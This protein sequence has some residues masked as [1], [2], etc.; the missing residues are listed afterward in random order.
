MPQSLSS[1]QLNQRSDRSC[2]FSQNVFRCTYS[3]W[4]FYT[5]I[6]IVTGLTSVL[7]PNASVFA[8]S[9][10]HSKP[11][12]TISE[13]AA[14]NNL[15]AK[16]APAVTQRFKELGVPGAIIGVW[17]KGYQPWIKTLGVSNLA[18]STP[19][20]RTDKMRIGSITKTFTGTV[21]L[22]L[23]DE[24]KVSL[25]DPVAKYILNVPN[26]EKITIR[27][28]GN[29][30]SGL[31]NYSEDTALSKKMSVETNIF[32]TPEQLLKIAFRNKPDFLP[33]EKANYS[34][35]NTVLLGMIIEKLTGNTLQNEIR[36]RITDPLGMQQTTFA[37]DG[38]MPRPHS[39]GYLYGTFSDPIVPKGTPPNNVTNNNPS[40]GWAAGAMIST[41]DDLYRYA[42]PLATGKFLSQKT[43]ADRLTWV[44]L[45][46]VQYGFQLG[47]FGGAIGHTGAIGGF[48]S[49]IGYLPEQDAT[50]IILTN[51]QYTWNPTKEGLEPANSLAQIII[52]ELQTQ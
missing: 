19:I 27:Q 35:T 24:G 26:G 2:V 37:I 23:V 7:W 39:Q 25:D 13:S 18:K 22:Q 1:D 44:K 10:I 41:L 50:V 6:G 45:G 30:T 46:E 28:I 17:A 9:A 42:K 8:G 21:F 38:K 43:Q 16:L 51:L 3:G 11:A 5:S 4:L 48:Q 15:E 34:N 29:M 36:T 40:W 20:Q 47:N 32:W 52:R 12:L 14:S 49:F 31:F 33:G